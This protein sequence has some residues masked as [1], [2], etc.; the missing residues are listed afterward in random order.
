MNA[1]L[2]AEANPN[3][4][5]IFGRSPLMLVSVLGEYEMA[6][7]LLKHKANVH[8]IDLF[9][10]TALSYAKEY[11]HKSVIRVLTGAGAQF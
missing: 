2:E 7:L 3:S 6:T 5:D 10:N 1:L 9:F 8:A 11:N 4:C